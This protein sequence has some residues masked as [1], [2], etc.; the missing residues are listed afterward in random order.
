MALIFQMKLTDY[1]RTWQ[2]G[3]GCWGK[4]AAR[5]LGKRFLK[6]MWQETGK[7]KTV[8]ALR[9][10][11]GGKMWKLGPRQRNPEENEKRQHWFSEGPSLSPM[12][13]LPHLKTTKNQKTLLLFHATWAVS[14]V[15]TIIQSVGACL[16]PSCSNTTNP[17]MDRGWRKMQKKGSL[18]VTALINFSVWSCKKPGLG[19]KTKWDRKS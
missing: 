11:S 1:D 19:V 5:P 15:S 17:P 8:I 9:W 16:I 10:A 4:I 6:Q 3:L 12:S 14:F 7:M 18:W 2:T 13:C